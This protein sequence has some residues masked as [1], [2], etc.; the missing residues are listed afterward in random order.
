MLEL[1]N[2][3][4]SGWDIQGMLAAQQIPPTNSAVTSS[5]KMALAVMDRMTVSPFSGKF[6]SLYHNPAGKSTEMR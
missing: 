4:S 2:V 3:A 1:G 6:N 5:V